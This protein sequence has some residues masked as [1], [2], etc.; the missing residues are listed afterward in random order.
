MV[1][2]ACPA[3]ELGALGRRGHLHDAGDQLLDVLAASFLVLVAEEGGLD[4]AEPAEDLL[5]G[6]ADGLGEVLAELADAVLDEPRYPAAC[7]G[8]PW[9][10]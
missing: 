7:R 6:K 3:R 8:F 4:I 1:A 2:A 10:P 9:P 5:L